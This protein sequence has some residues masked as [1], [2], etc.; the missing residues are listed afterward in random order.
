VTDALTGDTALLLAEIALSRG[1]ALEQ[2][3]RLDEAQADYERALAAVRSAERGRGWLESNILAAI[4]HVLWFQDR[5]EAAQTLIPEALAVARASGMP[6]VEARLLYTAGAVAWARTD[7]NRAA[8]LHRE[9]LEVALAADDLEGQAYA[10]HGLTETGLF[11]GPFEDALEEAERSRDLWRRLGW[12]PMIHHGSEL[13]GWLLVLLGRLDDAESVIEETLA[14]Q[15]ELGERRNLPFTLVVRTLTE[16]ARGALG[17]ALASAGEAIEIAA[18]VP[19]YRPALVARLFRA[20]LHAE[21]SAPDLAEQDLSTARALVG[22]RGRGLFHPPILAASGWL[23][24][25]SGDR[26]AARHTFEEA[27]REAR[28]SILHRLVCAWFELRAWGSVGDAPALRDA[29]TWIL[30]SDRHPGVSTEALASWSLALADALE[31]QKE[32]AE[33]ARAA[34][35]LAER[36]GDATVTWRAATLAADTSGDPAQSDFFR[37]RA[38]DVVHGMADSLDDEELRAR[39]LAQPAISAL[40]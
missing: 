5:Y 15:R 17:N 36:A 20:L 8:S 7:W 33:R 9:A 4:A 19:T 31:G 10:R 3:S 25:A 12:R 34:L 18:S 22:R 37:R 26:D 1:E 11:R 30:G 28:D 6:D 13:L 27:R 2:L 14:G 35:D 24:L 29:A 40:V 32:A 38:R 21:I 23:Q 16:L 39:F